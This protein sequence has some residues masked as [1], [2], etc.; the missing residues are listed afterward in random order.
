VEEKVQKSVQAL[1]K[2]GEATGALRAQLEKE[3]ASVARAKPGKGATAA[4]RARPEERVSDVDLRE[5]CSPV[6]DQGNI[7]SCTAQAVCGLAEYLERSL[8]GE[9]IDYSRLY[10]YK[11][12][13]AYLGWTGDTG[14]LVR[15]TIKALRLFGVAP[16]RFYPYV[17]ERFDEEPGAFYC[18]FGSNYK[19]ADFYRL[20]GLEALKDSLAKGIPFAFGFTCY[21]SLFTGQVTKTGD[22]P[23]PAKNEKVVG[24]HAVMAVGYDDKKGVLRFRNSWGTGWGEEGYGTLPYEYVEQGIATDFWALLNMNFVDIEQEG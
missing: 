6:E 24:G 20:E 14:A 4:L 1:A 12:T 2:Q 5:L 8:K 9:F 11:V 23:L 18:A 7:G 16:E 13:R 22:V 17:P 15:S 21:N 10:L 19:A 3:A